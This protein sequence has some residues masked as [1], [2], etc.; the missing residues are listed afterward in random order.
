MKIAE[1]G[2]WAFI[3][4]VIIAV[5]ASLVTIDATL[6]TGA[7][8][9]IGLIVGLINVTEKETRDFLLAA[10]SVVIVSYFSGTGFAAV[11]VIGTILQKVTMGIMTFVTPA[12]IIVALK[13]IWAIAKSA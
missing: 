4:G 6:V 5:L 12:V 8:V 11:P 10:V 9:L 13:Q 1:I 3:A 2:S 7:L